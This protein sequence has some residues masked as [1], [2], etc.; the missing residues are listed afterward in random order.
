MICFSL[1]GICTTRR[2]QSTRLSSPCE[3]HDN[4]GR[5]DGTDRDDAV[6][7]VVRPIIRPLENGAANMSLAN[8]KSTPCF[9]RFSAAFAASHSKSKLVPR[10]GS[11]S[12]LVPYGQPPLYPSQRGFSPPMG[13]PKRG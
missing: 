13:G 1:F 6:L 10:T 9:L 5:I 3:N 7:V 12:R 2:D 8:S 11:V 4:F